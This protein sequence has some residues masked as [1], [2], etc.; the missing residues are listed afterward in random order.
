MKS[1][2]ISNNEKLKKI[3]SKVYIDDLKSKLILQK[4]FG[5]MKKPKSLEFMKYNKKIQKRLNLDFK[6]YKY[7]SQHNSSIE[8]ELMISDDKY[9]IFINITDKNYYHIYFDNSEEEIKRNYLNENEK[10]KSIKI[11]IDY[12]VISF[13]ELFSNCT[14]ISSIFF[15]KFYRINITN[16]SYMFFNC[17]SLK[18]LNLSNIKTNVKDMSHMCY[19]CSS[20]KKINFSNF[21]TN[22]VRNMRGMFSECSSLKELNLTDF[23]TKNV[24]DM[25][26]MFYDCSSL[27]EINLSSF[28][29]NN[30][31][32]IGYMFYNC[33]SLKELNLSNFNTNNV[34]D[35]SYMFSGCSSI[36]KLNLP[37]FNTNNVI[38]MSYMFYNCSSLRELNISYFNTYDVMDKSF[39]FGKCPNEL[40]K[41]IKISKQGITII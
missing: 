10:V 15:K 35:M 31:T 30:V 24:T 4:I 29:I 9:G 32:D 20:L 5:H 16:M 1:G 38:N 34:A 27:T 8:I 14:C 11:I 19:H 12:Q 40:K 17:S 26:Y 36:K 18:E 37:N 13:K 22:N 25:R 28:N 33:S 7:Y 6:F 39:M 23:I 41:R 2:N 3:K 21:N